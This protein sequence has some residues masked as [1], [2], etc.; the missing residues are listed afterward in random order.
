MNMEELAAEIIRAQKDEMLQ[1]GLKRSISN[2]FRSIDNVLKNYPV[3]TEIAEHVKFIREEVLGNLEYYVDKAIKSISATG[4]HAYFAENRY[5]ALEIVDKIIGDEKKV[6]VKAKSMVTEEIMLREHLIKRG[7]EVYETDIGELLIQVSRGKPMHPIVPALHLSREQAA[8]LLRSHL[9]LNVGENATHEEMVSCIRDF[10][11]EKFIR[12]DVGISGANAI[13]A[14]TGSIFLVHNEGNISNIVT[15]PPIYIVITG[16]EKIVPTFKDAILQVMVQAGY[17]GLYPPTYVNVISGISSTADIEYHRVHGVHCAKEI[18]V[19]LY[20]GGRIRATKDQILTEQLRCIKCGRCQISCPIWSICGNIWG[21]KVYGGPM[22]VGW[23]AITEGIETA[24]T[25]SWFCLLCNACKELCPVKVDSAGI[26]RKLKSRGIERGIVPPKVKDMLENIYKHG[27][28]FGLP[29]AKRSEWAGS[30]IPRFRDGLDFLYYIG[31]MGSFHPRAQ[32]AARS[33]AEILLSAAVPYGILG[34]AES[35]SGSEAY[36]VGE[37]G[38]FEEIVKRNVKTFETLGV[39]KI[40]TLSPHSYNVMKNFYGEFGGK[41][42]VM[43]YTQLLWLLIKDGRIEFSDKAQ[44]NKII[45]Y[46]D[47]CFLGRWNGEYDAPRN[48]LRA[49]PGVRLIEMERNRES[50]LCCGGGSG[51]CYVG[52]GCGLLS[53]SRYNPDRVRVKEAYD[54][55]AE[56]LAVACPSCLIMLEEAVKA[57]DLENSLSVKDI[58]EIV[59]SSLHLSDK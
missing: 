9:G 6:V 35:C 54:A 8:S 18:H 40:V 46:H 57:E 34:E 55:G 27:N 31:D 51:N 7:H 1:L 48:I 15:L 19:I 3:L 13:A 4:A 11:K 2:F 26:S 41:F 50:S 47:P 16:V 53:E 32:E 17:A 22:G 12:A 49:I 59:R 58:S 33:L 10:L 38:L 39:K 30:Y 20:D 43:H 36:E 21:G 23:T 44:F 52:F 25:I 14:D 24:E 45:A 28:P 29:R 42:D 37:M 56:V 5:S